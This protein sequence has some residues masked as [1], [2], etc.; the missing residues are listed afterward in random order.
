MWGK[1]AAIQLEQIEKEE[2]NDKIES[3]CINNHMK[4]KLS[5]YNVTK[6][7]IIT[8]DT[9]Q[10]TT[11]VAILI[12]DNVEFTAEN[13]TM[14]KEG[15]FIIIKAPIHQKAYNPICT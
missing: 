3:N 14:D 12:P 5:Q 13:I 8:S 1:M 10:N 4:C 9:S 7:E 15:H 6:A 11:G 2:K